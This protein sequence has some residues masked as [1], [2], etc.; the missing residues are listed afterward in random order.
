MCINFRITT[1]ETNDL[2]VIICHEIIVFEEK[3]L[4]KFIVLPRMLPMLG[5]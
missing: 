4:G 2:F 5:G 1:K 3:K